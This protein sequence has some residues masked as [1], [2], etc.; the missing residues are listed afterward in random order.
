VLSVA[1]DHSHAAFVAE[2]AELL[3]RQA[4]QF[5][6]STRCAVGECGVGR[7]VV[8]GCPDGCGRGY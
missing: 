3:L 6:L 4:A 1:G 5:G 7:A 8:A 2:R